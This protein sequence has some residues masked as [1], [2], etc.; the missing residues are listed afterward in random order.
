M[1]H[2]EPKNPATGELE[3]TEV[4]YPGEEHHIAEQAGGMKFA[5][6]VLGV[7]AL[8]AGV[9]Q[10]PGST[11]WSPS[12]SNRPRE[13]GLPHMHPT[14]SESRIGLGEGALISLAGIATAWLLYIKR[15]DLPV[16]FRE[17]FRW[18]HTLTV[19][20]W[21]G[22]EIIDFLIVNRSRRSVVCNRAF[23]RFVIDGATTGVAGLT[24]SAG[25]AVRDMSGLLRGYAVL[26]LFG[27]LAIVI[28]FL[29]RASDAEFDHLDSASLRPDRAAGPP[30]FSP[31]GSRRSAR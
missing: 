11:T 30:A 28:Y 16:R 7:L 15:P 3:D 5:M 1:I 29:I 4:G 12:S 23:E 17:R 31:P 22:D 21:Y 24:R 14:T 18:I 10:I 26:M 19:N 20:K 9:L 8:I 27:I 6:A 25:A 2:G 13:L